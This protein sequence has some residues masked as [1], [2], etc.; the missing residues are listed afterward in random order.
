MLYG[1]STV[2]VQIPNSGDGVLDALDASSTRPPA[3]APDT[4]SSTHWPRER[5]SSKWWSD[6]GVFADRRVY[7]W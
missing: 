1:I 4:P 6:R 3:R 2:F 5:I 7:A